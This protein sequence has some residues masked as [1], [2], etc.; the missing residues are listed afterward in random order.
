MSEYEIDTL[1]FTDEGLTVQ[2]MEVPG[3]IRSGGALVMGRQLSLSAKHPDYAEDLELLRRSATR[4]LR[5]ALDDWETS[6]PMTLEDLEAG[7]E[8]EPDGMGM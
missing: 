3:D 2:Y 5:N 1:H 4:V 8:D 6:E 7:V